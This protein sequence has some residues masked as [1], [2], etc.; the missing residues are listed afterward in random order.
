MTPWW[1]RIDTVSALI[2]D[3]FASTL[4]SGRNSF[5]GVPS[6]QPF[7]IPLTP[8]IGRRLGDRA[9]LLE[10]GELMDAI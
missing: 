3:G 8:C 10:E 7:S 2:S 9:R 1:E 5:S 6:P 4:N